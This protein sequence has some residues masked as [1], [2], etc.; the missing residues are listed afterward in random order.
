MD[1]KTTVA[2]ENAAEI[3]IGRASF[4][5]DGQSGCCAIVPCGARC[6]DNPSALILHRSI[7]RDEE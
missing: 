1:V 7:G 5:A 4:T 2:L 3:A 6:R